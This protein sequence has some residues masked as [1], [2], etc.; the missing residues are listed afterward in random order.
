[1]QNHFGSIRRF[2]K[3][4]LTFLQEIKDIF[5]PNIKKYRRKYIFLE[6]YINRKLKGIWS[7]D[8]YHGIFHKQNAFL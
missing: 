5:G 6:K 3:K 4:N 1:M 7:N 8:E 2:K